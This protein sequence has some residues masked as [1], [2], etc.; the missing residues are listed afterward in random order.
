MLRGQRF[1]GMRQLADLAGVS[2]A[3]PDYAIRDVKVRP[4]ALCM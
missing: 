4:T 3:D 2:D 1:P